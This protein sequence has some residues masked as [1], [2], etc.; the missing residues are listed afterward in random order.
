MTTY[1]RQFLAYTTSYAFLYG[2]TQWLEEGRGL[3]ASTAGLILLPLSATALGISSSP[4]A[5]RRSAPSCSSAVPCRSWAVPR[6][7]W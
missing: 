4:G 2:Y 5:V 7:C 6:C 1:I 3:S